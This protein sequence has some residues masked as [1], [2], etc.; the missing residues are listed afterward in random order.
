MRVRALSVVL[1]LLLA[2]G[3]VEA[4]GSDVNLRA[5]GVAD[6][7][8]CGVCSHLLQAMRLLTL[9]QLVCTIS[10]LPASGCSISDVDCICRDTRLAQTVS[11]CMLANCTMQESLQTARVQAEQ[12]KLSEDSKRMEVFT[13]TIIVYSLAI[14]CVILRIAGKLISKKLSYDD[15][16]VVFAILISAL[17]VACVISSMSLVSVQP[18]STQANMVQ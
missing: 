13:Y 17:P 5:L 18:A 16:I 12:C 4:V 6:I 8:P 3:N 10:A 14:L 1:W 9:S 15:Y 7:P 2:T 11:G